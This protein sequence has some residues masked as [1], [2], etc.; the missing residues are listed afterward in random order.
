MKLALGTVQFGLPY[1][2]AGRKT[3][4]P[5]NEVRAILEA[6]WKAGVRT[7]DTAAA[8]GDIEDRLGRLSEGLDFCIISKIPT[9]PHELSDEE[10]ACWA[11]KS[12][13]QSWHRLGGKLT[14]LM[15]HRSEDLHGSRGDVIWRELSA[16]AQ[17]QGVKLGA[18]CYAPG[19]FVFLHEKI[20]LGLAQLP[21]NAFDQRIGSDLPVPLPDVEIHLR[22]AFLQGL[23][24]M[25]I[26]LATTK[27]PQAGAALMQWHAWCN[28]HG[29][30]QLEAA[31]SAVK[32]FAAVSEVVVGVDSEE[33]LLEISAAWERAKPA[34]IASLAVD[35]PE[36]IDPRL[37][38]VAA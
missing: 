35:A 34:N 38:K 29:V 8:Y 24:L 33:Q 7:L 37:W 4:V 12:A 3:A 31:L 5:E 26:S 10:A 15:L 19:D 13:E 20:G 6:A 18:S 30:D 22:S 21:G 32:S 14:G 27:L 16:W 9:V 17:A 23:L 36:I 1:G 28:A 11:R 25:P 2:I